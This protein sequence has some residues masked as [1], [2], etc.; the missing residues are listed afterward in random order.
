[1]V[2]ELGDGQIRKVIEIAE[3][4]G[5]EPFFVSKDYCGVERFLILALR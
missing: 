3:D 4:S 1:M 5:F 2:M